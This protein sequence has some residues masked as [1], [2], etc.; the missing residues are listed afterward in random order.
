MSK[1]TLGPWIVDDSG[2]GE[3]E[4][5][6]PNVNTTDAIVT[7]GMSEED[8]ANAHLIAAAPEMYEALRELCDECDHMRD[9]FMRSLV[10]HARAA[11]AKAEG[12]DA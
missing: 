2:D 9:D 3:Y 1:H 7:L 5:W 10:R 6:A 12:R 11:L 4:V 8:A